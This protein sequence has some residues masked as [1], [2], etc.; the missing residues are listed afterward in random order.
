MGST[1]LKK[2]I[3]SNFVT[4]VSNEL[5]NIKDSNGNVSIGTLATIIKLKIQKDTHTSSNN[6]FISRKILNSL[7]LKRD[8]LNEVKESR[9]S[10]LKKSSQRRLK[11][12]Y[13]LIALQMLFTQWGTYVQYSWDIME[14]I[15]NIFG[16][17]DMILAYTYWMM[18]DNSF[19]FGS[20]QDDYLNSTVSKQLGKEVNFNEEM[21]DIEDMIG[22]IKIFEKLN[23][24]SDDMAKRMEGLDAKF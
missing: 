22:H 9:I 12:L 2:N 17:V 14:P 3:L 6:L 1:D 13:S 24:S 15:A 18:K 10:D 5:L 7:Y 4:Q 20:F 8:S 16:I 23:T 19:N 11:A 21:E